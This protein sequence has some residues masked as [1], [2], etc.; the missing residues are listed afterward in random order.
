VNV[1]QSSS[2]RKDFSRP[3]VVV[4]LLVAAID[5]SVQ[6]YMVYFAA[7]PP[8]SIFRSIAAHFEPAHCQCSDRRSKPGQAQKIRVVHVLDSYEEVITPK[9]IVD[10]LPERRKT[11]SLFGEPPIEAGALAKILTGGPNLS[12]D[13]LKQI[14]Y[15]TCLKDATKDVVSCRNRGLQPKAD[16]QEWLLNFVWLDKPTLA[17]KLGV[18]C[19]WSSS[20]AHIKDDFEKLMSIKAPLKPFIY[21]TDRVA[22]ERVHGWLRQWM[23]S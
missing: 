9:N 21:A 14:L 5:Y 20:E 12:W 17:I 8:R 2:R 18:E 1:I 23:E 10:F 22:N 19:E 6:R 15:D 7:K 16:V 11:M 3:G 13:S 4:F